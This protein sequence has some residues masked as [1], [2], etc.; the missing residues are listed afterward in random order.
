M[1]PPQPTHV[2]YADEANYNTGRYRSVALVSLGIGDTEQLKQEIQQILQDLKISEFKWKKLRS[3]QYRFAALKI[4]DCVLNWIKSKKIRVDVIIWDVGDS[5]HTIYNR[6]DIRN[7]R[8]MYYFLTRNVLG[9]RWPSSCV[10]E[11]RPD[12]SSFGAASHLRYLGN[13]DELNEDAKRVNI[14]QIVE[15]RSTDEPLVQV[16]DLFAGLAVYSRNS[17]HIYKSWIES[18]S[19]LKEISVATVLSNS[20]KERCGVLEH[21]HQQCKKQKLSVSLER[22]Q[23]LK[24]MDARSALNFWL[25]EAQGD[26]DKAP[27]WH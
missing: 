13:P 26:Y 21:L 4:I 2:A 23:G 22:T 27:I 6:S 24:T 8:R 18:I 3:A 10:W 12:E 9:R 1:S 14:S 20:D 17:F 16:A 7:L 15:I 11:L 5:R 25:Y 19:P